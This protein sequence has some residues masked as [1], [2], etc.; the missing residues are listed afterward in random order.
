MGVKIIIRSAILVYATVWMFGFSPAWAANEPDV[1]SMPIGPLLDMEVYTAARF[2]QKQS[3]AAATISVLTAAEIKRFGYRPISDVLRSL[4]VFYISNERN[5]DSVGVHGLSRAGG[6]NK[7]ILLPADGY[8]FSD[9]VYGNASLS[10]I[11]LVW[12]RDWTRHFPS[13]IY[14]TGTIVTPPRWNISTA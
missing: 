8:R 5:Y 3:E 10:P 11:H 4:P 6:D 1:A 12:T 13:A 7:R 2:S 9:G 14:L